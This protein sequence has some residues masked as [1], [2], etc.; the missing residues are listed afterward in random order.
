M[1]FLLQENG[2]GTELT[3]KDIHSMT[4]IEESD[5]TISCLVEHPSLELSRGVVRFRPF[6]AILNRQDLIAFL[7][8]TYP[9]AVRRVHLHGLYTFVDADLDDLLLRGELLCVDERLESLIYAPCLGVPAL[10]TTEMS[11]RFLK[12]VGKTV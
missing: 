5:L 1:I 8:H 11:R 9:Q 2:A 6:A 4:D 3:V 7:R 12:L 10:F